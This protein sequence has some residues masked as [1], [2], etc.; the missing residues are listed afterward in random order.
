MNINTAQSNSTPAQRSVRISVAHARPLPLLALILLPLSTA[1]AGPALG[2]WVP[3]FEGIEQA[4]GTN[5]PN[6]A[7]N[8]PELQ[9]VYCMRVNLTD[10]NLQ[11]FTTPKAPG[12]VAESRETLT[13]S[14][15]DFLA[16]H[17]LQVV[18]DANYYNAN[19][20]GAD[21]T[22]EGLP[23]EVYGLQICTG[24][25][26][27]AVSSAD[28][29][30]D[31]RAASLL[32]T[33]NKQ[34][35]FDFKNI[36]PGTNTAGIYTA[37]TGF[38]PI[39]SNGV[40]WGIAASNSYADPYIHELQPRTAYGVS[41]DNHYFFILIIDGR[42]GG[43]SDGAYD[44]ETGCWMTNC[45][46]WNAINMDGGGSTALYQAN[47][48]G[49]PV[50]INHSS[51]LPS[52]GR[53]RYVGSHFGIYA[54]PVPGFFTNIAVMAD[55]TAATL[56]WTTI[57]AATTQLQYGTATNMT[58]LTGSNAALTVNHA[59]LVTN[60]IPGTNYYYSLLASIGTN[61]YVSPPYAFT[62][63]NYVTSDEV[64]DFTNV[65]TYTSTNLD[66]VDWTATD[67]DDSGW[68]GSGPGLLWV[69]YRGPDSEIPNLNT[70]MDYDN[71]YPFTTYYFR[72][73]FMFTNNPAGVALQL[74]GYI[75]DGAVFYLNGTEVGRLRM[76]AGTIDNSTYATNY[77]CDGD[78][79][80]ID[81]LSAE[82]PVVTNSLIVGDNVMAAEAHT[83]SAASPAITFGLAAYLAV[84]YSVKPELSLAQTN[85]AF[86]ISW[87]QGGYFL[88]QAAAITGPWTNVPGLVISSPF[89]FTNSG[90]SR[91]FRLTR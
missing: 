86:V 14:V 73:H 15:P 57:S 87:A 50:A 70:Q 72:T 38:Y 33:T 42:Q 39:V 49:N 91:F 52:Y 4:V 8:F 69:D 11:F 40:N 32:F 18:A 45:G 36:P 41:K 25:V 60:L 7:G 71:G 54:P 24:A 31:P 55:D 85:H 16:Q 61:R 29:A 27:S 64:F 68:E 20:G 81:Y 21:P 63:T 48:A 88:Q 65:W 10:P 59:V 82:G 30:G 83:L 5:D 47:S 9:V 17:K 6:V 77:P 37:I 74:Q 34:P 1:L 51:Y 84:P 13:L 44:V 58:Q 67:Y 89:T 19:P 26:V 22:S 12:Y 56:T 66:G 3:I 35:I 46:A 75:D 79:T 23:C 80:C 53:E 28:Y 62:T 90:S 78:A 2:P 76:P 43:Y